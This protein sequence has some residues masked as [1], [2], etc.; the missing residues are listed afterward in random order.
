MTSCL[1]ET[2]IDAPVEDVWGLVGD[3]RTYPDW[4]PRFIEV[5]GE[6]FEEG[7]EFLQVSQ[8]PVGR[9]ESTYLIEQLDDLREVR[10]SCLKSG[11]YVDWK[12]TPAQDGTFVAA[13][14]G[15]NPLGLPYRIFDITFA[16]RYFRKWLEQTVEALGDEA[17]SRS[18][19]VT[20]E[21][22]E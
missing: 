10:V 7:S 6:R 14:F 5:R 8:G 18:A 3:P 11:H 9:V 12:M 1:Q 13:E 19:S 4:W 17:R 21:A 16:R 22:R 15:I 20:T 2:L